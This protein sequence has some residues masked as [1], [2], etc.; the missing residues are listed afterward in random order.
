MVSAN[1]W[2]ILEPCLGIVNAC[3]PVLQPALAKTFGISAL[4]W[5]HRST[6]TASSVKT[7]TSLWCHQPSRISAA[8]ETDL[9][10]PRFSMQTKSSA[11]ANTWPQW[12]HKAKSCASANTFPGRGERRVVRFKDV[13]W[14]DY[15]PRRVNTV[16]MSNFHCPGAR[17]YSAVAAKLHELEDREGAIS[18]CNTDNVVCWE[19]HSMEDSG[20]S[21]QYWD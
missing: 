6:L 20:D 2:S 15:F 13:E 1:I 11:T 18:P 3:L 21:S 5:S 12:H 10:W 9:Q 14:G 17:S 7:A 8:G 19:S 16:P 4:D